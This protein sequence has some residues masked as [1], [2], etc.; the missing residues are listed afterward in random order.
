MTAYNHRSLGLINQPGSLLHS[1]QGFC[2]QRVRC[3]RGNLRELD[4]R[5]FQLNVP[6]YIN[7]HRTWPP[8]QSGL[9]GFMNGGSQ[10]RSRH[11]HEGLFSA[12]GCDAANIAFLES[13]R[14]QSSPGYLPRYC[15]HRHRVCLGAHYAGHQVGSAGTRSGHAHADFARDAG[16]PISGVGG[17]LLV[18]HQNMAQ[19]RVT[20]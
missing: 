7:Q 15:D 10:V 19:L 13:F 3:E 12:G 2:A 8:L 17:G 11:D 6:R 1:L 9:E 14:S 5:L 18:A 20:P 16:I 4:F